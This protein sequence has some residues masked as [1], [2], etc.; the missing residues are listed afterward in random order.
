MYKE[1]K[2][3]Y[4]A[5]GDS[6]L[7]K[8]MNLSKFL[9]LLNGK[10]YFNRIDCFEDKFEATY[11]KCNKIHKSIISSGRT[12]E[13]AEQLYEK[14]KEMAQNSMYVSCFHRNDFESAFMWKQY[15]DADGI[16]I[17]TSVE[18]L[19]KC[20]HNEKRDIYICDVKYIDY[21]NEFMPENNI[22]YLGLHKRKSFKHEEEVRCIYTGDF[23]VQNNE[24]GVLVETDLDVL[25]EKVYISPHAPTYLAKDVEKILRLYNINAEVVYSPLYTI[26][27]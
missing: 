7:W 26:N 16:A 21:D 1:F 8:Y 10:M 18:K 6:M 12:D 19:K 3:K 20:F 27:K 14:L 15:A 23:T 5:Q 2:E 4:D 11:P 9:N 17:Q 22:Y 13:E 24:T 25:I